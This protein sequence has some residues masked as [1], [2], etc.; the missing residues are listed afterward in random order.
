MK[1]ENRRILH[2]ALNFNHKPKFNK[3]PSLVF[4]DIDDSEIV[5]I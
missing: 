3:T 4:T 5:D 1:L 2:K